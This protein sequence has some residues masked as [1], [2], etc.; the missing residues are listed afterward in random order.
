MLK[1]SIDGKLKKGS[2]S[3]IAVMFLVSRKTV[4]RLWKQAKTFMEQGRVFDVGILHQLRNRSKKRISMDLDHILEIPLRKQ[5]NIR[6][7][8]KALDVSKSTLHR[9]IKEGLIKPHTNA[10][11]PYLTDANKRARVH[12]CLT[13]LESG[14]LNTN[15][16]FIGMFNIVHIDEKWFYLSKT[17]KKYYLHPDEIEPYRTCKS[18]RFTTK[19]K[20][21]AAMARPHFDATFNCVFS[22]KIGIFPFVFKE[23]ARHNSKNRQVGTLETKPILSVTKDVTRSCLIDKVLP[24]I[25]AKWTSYSDKTIFIQQDNAK[26]HIGVDD[27]EFLQA[28][29]VDDFNFHPFFQPPNNHDLNVLDLGYF[30]AIQSLQHEE[31]DTTIDE[32][33]NA[34][35]KSFDELAPESLNNVFLSLQSCMIEIMKIKGGNNY[36]LPHMS[37]Q[38]LERNGEL[39]SQLR[40]DQDIVQ[41]A[42]L[43]IQLQH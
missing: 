25:R 4:T 11:K 35:E 3:K 5:T 28:A 39:P 22:R 17:S 19:M 20:F 14:T 21:L 2:V 42:L 38:S 15:P 10:M 13:M 7:M 18:K 12:F 41:E 36:I 1:Q 43:H 34:V 37:K 6:S 26:P 8:A 32:L 24:A 29:S 9:R 33:V 27:E 16:L 40:C 30:R 23:P 31:S